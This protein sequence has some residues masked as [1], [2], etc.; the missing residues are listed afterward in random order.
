MLTQAFV[1]EQRLESGSE[2]GGFDSFEAVAWDLVRVAAIQHLMDKHGFD[3][4][5]AETVGVDTLRGFSEWG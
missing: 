2:Y 1:A 5:T 3:R 4:E